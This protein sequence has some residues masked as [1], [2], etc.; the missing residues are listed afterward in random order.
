MKKK[1]TLFL[2][3]F[4]ICMPLTVKSQYVGK[5]YIMHGSGLHLAKSS[6]SGII[7][8]A[9]AADPQ[10]MNITDAGNG[11]FRIQACADD[12]QYRVDRLRIK[13]YGKGVW[14]LR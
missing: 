8:S 2:L 13:I 7:E 11:Y 6:K 14:L 9:S 1:L 5:H 3:L 12:H 10:I 4:T